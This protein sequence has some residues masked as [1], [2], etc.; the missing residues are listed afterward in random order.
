MTDVR[1]ERFSNKLNGVVRKGGGKERK[2][3]MINVRRLESE[4]A[5]PGVDN[6]IFR[7]HNYYY[8]DNRHAASRFFAVAFSERS[9]GAPVDE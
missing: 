3:E 7:L 4:I 5:G 6:T 9:F 8:F 2:R 1:R